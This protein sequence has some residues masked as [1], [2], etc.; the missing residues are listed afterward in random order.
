M[1]TPPPSR[2]SPLLLEWHLA[3]GVERAHVL[4]QGAL[5]LDGRGHFVTERVPGGLRV[6][7]GWCRA[8]CAACHTQTRVSQL[9][10]GGLVQLLC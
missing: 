4:G 3:R 8:R 2:L 5:A 9:C 10:R 7:R 6:R 1:T